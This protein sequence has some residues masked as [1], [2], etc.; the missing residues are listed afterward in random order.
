MGE[1]SYHS[2]YN[3]LKKDLFK[4][5]RETSETNAADV[6][7]S[8][9][10]KNPN[11]VENFST[12]SKSISK[13]LKAYCAS[14]SFCTSY[15]GLLNV[16]GDRNKVGSIPESVGE[17][18]KRTKLLCLSYPV[19]KIYSP[20]SERKCIT[21]I[22]SYH[23]VLEKDG[24]NPEKEGLIPE[25]M[26]AL[27]KVFLIVNRSILSWSF[28][29]KSL[30][31]PGGGGRPRQ[32]SQR[33]QRLAPESWRRDLLQ[34]CGDVHP[35]PG[36][37]DQ[38]SMKAPI[39]VISYNIRGLKDEKKMRHLLCHY[40]KK[41]NKDLDLIVCLQETFLEKPGKLP[42]IW[43]GNFFL[44]EG[45]GNSCGCITLLSSHLTVV[46]SKKIEN[47]AHVL[48]C[49]KNDTAR[50][51]VANLYAPNLNG[52]EKNEFYEK[53]FDAV[54]EFEQ[55]HNCQQVVIAGDFNLAFRR[56]ETKNRLFS[57]QERRVGD[58]VKLLMNAAGMTDC[59]QG[60]TSFTW[61][62]PN[63]DIFSTI[64]RVLFSSAS[65]RLIGVSTNWAL[66]YSDHAEVVANF[67]SKGEKC[68][69]RA[70]IPRLDPSLVKDP[71]TK[72]QIEV[73]FV[74]MLSQGGAE[75]DPHMR[76]E[77][78]KMCLRTVTERVQ[79][80]R[81]RR[82]KDEEELL[83][84]ELNLAINRLEVL[85]GASN[86]KNSLIEH[87]EEL[88][89]KKDVLIDRKGKRLAEKLGTKWY[90]EGEKSTRYFL[91]LL[92][93]PA[94]DKF[95]SIIKENGEEEKE[96][97]KIEEAIVNFYK[98]LYEKVE[99]NSN[100]LANA[101]NFFD[102]I[103][104]VSDEAREAILGPITEGE[105]WTTLGSCDDSA[106]GPDGIPYSF[107]RELW[108]HMGKLILEAWTYSQATGKLSTSHRGSFL[109]L[110]P[111]AGKDLKE[112]KN[113][114]PITLSNCDHKLIT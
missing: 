51:I 17:T 3:S 14:R 79:A 64:D 72:A 63:S 88:R 37:G 11:K 73:E 104:P 58:N 9:L 27:F 44:T 18:P 30:R 23:Y 68:F 75:W 26:I 6:C 71:N 70:R 43:R 67:E 53:V 96:E 102:N 77:Y 36:P 34:R 12:F 10:G 33:R 20:V 91:Q 89:A 111:K 2:V 105:L 109:R 55:T 52:R 60:K 47:R 24:L 35:N 13:R 66:S 114:R 21:S 54:F 78:A 42:F 57:T 50:Y 45:E 56:E 4:C 80:E 98:D 65:L 97:Q 5:S 31:R 84:E 48:V 16:S 40:Q 74:T 87:I 76:L 92:N 107:I 38:G 49:A 25:E 7:L 100:D 95:E 39:Q 69:Q 62:R 90:N 113:W 85:G 112:L 15:S 108:P 61:R 22:F 8:W 110:I 103:E 101:G 83:N 1:F 28:Q 81:K 106:P 82:E 29:C 86:G 32:Q 94:P 99:G 41:C 19:I 46:A 59:W 93:R